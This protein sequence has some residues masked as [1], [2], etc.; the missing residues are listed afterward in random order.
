MIS[1]LR[2]STLTLLLLLVRHVFCTSHSAGPSR[3]TARRALRPPF[4]DPVSSTCL[5]WDKGLV[6]YEHH[7][8]WLSLKY[9]DKW[10]DACNGRLEQLIKASCD[11]DLQ[12]LSSERNDA[13][14]ACV[15]NI[16]LVELNCM[17]HA[18]STAVRCLFP[19]AK[20]PH[21]EHLESE[22]NP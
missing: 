8:V 14:G 11:A 2:A 18:M 10:A 21:C 7:D 16:K 17:M 12:Q 9:K 20:I 13:E 4:A 6:D 5:Y 22:S 3:L 19:G 1:N 15:L